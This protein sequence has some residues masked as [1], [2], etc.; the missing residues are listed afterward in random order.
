MSDI[1]SLESRRAMRTFRNL[2]EI[3]RANPRAASE[4]IDVASGCSEPSYTQEYAAVFLIG[5]IR[6][7]LGL[8]LSA[9]GDLNRFL[10]ALQTAEDKSL[11]WVPAD[12]IGARRKY[13]RSFG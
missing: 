1:E 11:E 7:A 13:G 10:L 8:H 12:Y 3:A 4:V 6:G 5:L 9:H 2:F